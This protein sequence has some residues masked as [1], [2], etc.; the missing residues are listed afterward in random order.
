MKAIIQKVEKLS[1]KKETKP[2]ETQTEP[3]VKSVY[4]VATET[5]AIP[6]QKKLIF[7]SKKIDKKKQRW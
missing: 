6:K 1:K 3:N 4:S 7:N 2:M 5:Q